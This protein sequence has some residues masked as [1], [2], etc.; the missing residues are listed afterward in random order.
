MVDENESLIC[1]ALHK[2]LKRCK[3]ENMILE[4]LSVKNQI[5]DCITHLEEWNETKTVSTSLLWAMDKCQV[6]RMP[7]GTCLIIGT[8][9][10][11]VVLS[12]GP[13]APCLAGG[14]TAV[15]KFSEITPNIS[16]LLATLIPRYMDNRIV[17]CV[18]GAVPE[19]TCLLEQKFDLIFYTGNT[20][21]AKIIMQ[22]AAKTLTPVILELGGKS[23]VIVDE[24][25]DIQ[26][27]AKR[28]MW[29]KIT[30]CG[31]TCIAPDYILVHKKVAKQ[32]VEALKASVK[33]L[34]GDEDIK[35]TPYYGRI[36][37]QRHFDRLKKMLDDQKKVSGVELAYGGRTDR[38]QLFIEP[39]IFTGVTKDGNHPAM[40]DEIFGPLLPVIEIDNIQEAID[41][42]NSRPHPLSYY[43]QSKNPRVIQK[44]F[45]EVKGGNAVSNDTVV[46]FAVETLP[47]GG[48]GDSG[49]GAYHGIYGFEAFTRPQA[50]MTRNTPEFL[51]EPRYQKNA[52]NPKSFW[53]PLVKILL[54][55]KP[56][57]DFQL[58]VNQWTRTLLKLVG[59]SRGALALIV[60]LVIGFFIRK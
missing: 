14:N 3:D 25:V 12:L 48:I 11:A 53:H 2:D 42:V 49:L 45:D 13:L 56:P 35:T 28:V 17:K 43:P 8:W 36:S 58:T 54:A 23:P 51:S 46:N 19:I 27:S 4:V 21:V 1:D 18:T 40:K 57:S 22:Q 5:A 15:I 6:K 37:S 9:N 55:A 16:D 44:V 31:Q 60:G 30:N 52:L 32:Y 24:N 10:Y 59:G 50:F 47:F 33:D 38:D 26:V 7:F 20:Q 34:I 39:T 29:G 41:F